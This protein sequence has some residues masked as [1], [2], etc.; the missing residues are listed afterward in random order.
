MIPSDHEYFVKKEEQKDYEL[1][2]YRECF[3]EMMLWFKKN[4][5]HLKKLPVSRKP[6]FPKEVVDEFIA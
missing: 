1:R 4:K 2:V 5:K 6:K 3:F